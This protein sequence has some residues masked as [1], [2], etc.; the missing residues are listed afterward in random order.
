MDTTGISVVSRSRFCGCIVSHE[1]VP[2]LI[3]YIPTVD[4]NMETR[5]SR[6][7]TIRELCLSSTIIVTEQSHKEEKSEKCL[8][9]KC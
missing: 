1:V 7:R 5:K 9:Y 3:D 6:F 2:R 8:N 4:A